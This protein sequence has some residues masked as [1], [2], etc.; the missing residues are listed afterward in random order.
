MWKGLFRRPTTV[1]ENGVSSAAQVESLEQRQLLAV[2]PETI[3]ASKI[4]VKNLFDDQGLSI[5]QSQLTVR[6]TSNVTLADP[7][8]VRMIGYVINPVGG[9]QRKVTVRLSDI[10]HDSVNSPN[11]ITFKTDSLSPKTGRI[12]I[13]AGGVKDPNG[14]DI[15]ANV[16]PPKGQNK[17]RFTLARRA[18]RP[19]D[20]SLFPKYVDPAGNNG[21]TAGTD[22]PAATVTGN[23]TSFMRRKRDAGLITEAQR[24][25]AVDLYNNATVQSIVPNA[26]LRAALAS[27]VGTVGEPA[28]ASIINGQNSTGKPWT[29]VDFSSEARPGA[30][31]A[32]SLINPDTG[33]VR[34]L[35]K[36]EYRGEPF[37]A[38]AGYLA[39]ETMHIESNMSAGQQEEI[40]T[41]IVENLVYAHHVLGF[42]GWIF[43]QTQL[44]QQGNAELLAML[45]SGSKVFP[46]VGVSSAPLQNPAG[47]VFHN[48][49]TTDTSFE[50]FVRR[51]YQERN[52]GDFNTTGNE[53]WQE[54][55]TLIT[56][57]TEEANYNRTTISRIDESQQIITDKRAIALAGALGLTNW[58]A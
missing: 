14:N 50:A 8:K 51:Q 19:T 55:Y 34:M 48:G 41:N 39:H 36:V 2:S 20:L 27:L 5:N 38:L 9:A 54:M 12:I 26:N 18:F 11:I 4:K 13:D 29:V 33:R 47:K 7:T 28:I 58:I 56:G 49:T 16:Q 40:C 37:Q 31:V 46:R 45:N 17:E 42:R 35:F 10:T 23:F 25:Q 52:F 21:A 3:I 44:T 6:F 53:T 22:V 1:A 32:E 30:V 43:S 15:V 24:Q 57:R